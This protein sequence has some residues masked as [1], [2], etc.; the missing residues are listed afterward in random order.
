MSVRCWIAGYR[1]KSFKSLEKMIM[2]RLTKIFPV[3]VM[4]LLV[5]SAPAVIQNW[6][7]A[8][9]DTCQGKVVEVEN[10]LLRTP[11]ERKEVAKWL[12]RVDLICPLA[13]V[14]GPVEIMDCY[15][16]GDEITFSPLQWQIRHYESVQLLVPTEIMGISR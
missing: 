10:P 13:G 16:A 6:A 15:A 7:L 12:N 9:Y 2:K 3:Y 1:N 4:A 8:E 14:T 5:L 11:D